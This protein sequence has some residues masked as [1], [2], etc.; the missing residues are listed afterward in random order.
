MNK[1]R[2]KGLLSEYGS[3][4]LWTYFA[5]FGLVFVG[6]AIA[7]RLGFEAPSVS[8]Q[9]GLLA[10]A[11]VATKVTQPLRIGATIVLTPLLA[12]LLRKRRRSPAVSGEQRAE[13]GQPTGTP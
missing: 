9:A 8:G 2:L 3:V 11:Y 10:A 4:A 5:I 12:H 13:G 7:I 6:F 1:E